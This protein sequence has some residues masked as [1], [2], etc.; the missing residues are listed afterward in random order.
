MLASAVGLMPARSNPALGRAP[1]LARAGASRKAA[2]SDR[3]ILA[4]TGF[5]RKAL[6]ADLSRSVTSCSKGRFQALP[7][8]VAPGQVLPFNIDWRAAEN[9]RKSKFE[10][11][12]RRQR[13]AKQ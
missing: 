4:D 7:G 9:C 13:A 5:P 12:S 11:R 1:C 2:R 3:L 6:Q 8:T 10:V